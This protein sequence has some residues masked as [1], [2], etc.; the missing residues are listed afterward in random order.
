MREIIRITVDTTAA[1]GGKY[2]TDSRRPLTAT[3]MIRNGPVFI[4]ADVVMDTRGHME[5]V[6]RS[7]GDDSYLG[8]DGDGL[9]V[10]LLTAWAA[11]IRLMA[12]EH[13]TKSLYDLLDHIERAAG[14]TTRGE[15]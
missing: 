5:P 2:I 1:Y 11:E 13:E 12:R 6:W 14:E 9:P 3:H 10:D 7:N 4:T 8:E 15:D